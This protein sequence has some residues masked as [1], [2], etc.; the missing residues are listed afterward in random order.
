MVI[1]LKARWFCVRVIDFLLKTHTGSSNDNMLFDLGVRS[2]DLRKSSKLQVR[3][4]SKI[5]CAMHEYIPL[6]YISFTFFDSPNSG[7]YVL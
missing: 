7:W 4:E 1:V 5:A 2:K 3:Y 6:V